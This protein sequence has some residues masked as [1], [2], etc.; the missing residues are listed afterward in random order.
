MTI[1]DYLKTLERF[2]DDPYGKQIRTCFA[3]MDGRSE[4]AVLQAPSRMEYAQLTRVVARMSPQ[5]KETAEQLSQARIEQLA[6]QADA[7]PALL[8]IFLNGYALEKTRQANIQKK[9]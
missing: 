2:V 3:G 7:D 9:N 1:D 5:E 6:R 8:A 4:L